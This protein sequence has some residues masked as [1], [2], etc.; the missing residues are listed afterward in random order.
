L[1][2]QNAYE[3]SV[4][5]S[6]LKLGEILR[7]AGIITDFQ[8]DSALSH[9]RHWGGRLGKSLIKLGYITEDK[10]LSFLAQQFDLPQIDLDDRMIPQDVLSY[11]SAEKALEYQVIPV[12]RSVVNGRT[13]LV[14]AMTDPTNLWMIDSLQFMTGYRIKPALATAESIDKAIKRNYH[15]DGED[16]S[17]V[18]DFSSRDLKQ[19]IEQAPV[20]DLENDPLPPPSALKALE[21]RYE[22][23]VRILLDR[24]ILTPEDLD[25]LM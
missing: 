3:E 18:M 14:V 17:S 9:Q 22:N 5:A 19:P 6:N 2:N 15:L 7:N 24:G 21:D 13:R 16:S 20:I 8:L 25:E 12:E 11:I 23:L 4:V 1:P 10:L